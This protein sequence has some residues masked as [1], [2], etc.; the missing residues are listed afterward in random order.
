MKKYLYISIIVFPLVFFGLTSYVS[1]DCEDEEFLDNCASEI[2]GYKFLK[3][4]RISIKGS[5]SGQ[6]VEL[7][8][9]FSKGSTYILT[10]CTGGAEKMIVTLYDRNRKLIMS[11]YDPK[12]KKFFNKITYNCAATGVYYFKYEFEGGGAGCGVGIIGFTQK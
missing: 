7:S 3:A 9:V 11:N 10:A 5:K 12:S 4:N 1:S 6:T 8:N 2:T